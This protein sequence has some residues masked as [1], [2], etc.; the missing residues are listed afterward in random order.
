MKRSRLKRKERILFLVNEVIEYGLHKMFLFKRCWK[1][2]IS[3]IH[4]GGEVKGKCYKFVTI[5]SV[6]AKAYAPSPQAI[7][8]GHMQLRSQIFRIRF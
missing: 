3:I 2:S 8:N 4:N 7:L 6:L 5:Y 1:Y